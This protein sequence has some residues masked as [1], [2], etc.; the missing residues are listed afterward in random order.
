M[1]ASD[2]IILV[3]DGA[4]LDLDERAALTRRLQNELL[5]LHL[6]DGVRQVRAGTLPAGAKAGEAI[7]FGALAVS[8]A[9]EIAGQLV[10]FLAGWLRRQRTTMKIQIDGQTLEGQVTQEQRDALVA[11]YLRRVTAMETR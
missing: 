2:E 9:P 10:D 11:A 5:G 4:D 3:L 7:T 1:P 6:L 8:F